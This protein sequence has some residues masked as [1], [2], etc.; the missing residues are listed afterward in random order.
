MEKE[1]FTMSTIDMVATGRNIARLRG[2]AGLTVR[3]PQDIFGFV[4]PQT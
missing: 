2:E 1:M 4:T 3:N